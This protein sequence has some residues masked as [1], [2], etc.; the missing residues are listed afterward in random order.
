LSSNQYKEYARKVIRDWR[1]ANDPHFQH[2]VPKYSL[3]R[4]LAQIIALRPVYRVIM[5]Y[6]DELSKKSKHLYYEEM[7][8]IA[9]KLLSVDHF[10]L[11]PQNYMSGHLGLTEEAIGDLKLVINKIS[12]NFQDQ[13]DKIFYGIARLSGDPKTIEV[14]NRIT[15]KIGLC[16]QAIEHLHLL[17]Q[18]PSRKSPRLRGL[19]RLPNPLGS[20]LETL[21]KWLDESFTLQSKSTPGHAL[22]WSDWRA[23]YLIISTELIDSLSTDWFAGFPIPNWMV[24]GQGFHPEHAGDPMSLIIEE[25]T[26]TSNFVA[27]HIAHQLTYE[28]KMEVKERRRRLLQK[29]IESAFNGDLDW[30]ITEDKFKRIFNF[31]LEFNS[32]ASEVYIQDL[33]SKLGLSTSDKIT[34][35]DVWAGRTYFNVKPIYGLPDRDVGP[36]TFDDKLDIINDKIMNGYDG[37]VDRVEMAME[38]THMS[39]EEAL[40][41]SYKNMLEGTK[42]YDKF[43]RA[44][45]MVRILMI[46]ANNRLINAEK[47]GKIIDRYSWTKIKVLMNLDSE[48]PGDLGISEFQE[49]LNL[50][51]YL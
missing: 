29:A 11:S 28:C 21:L 48:Y 31:P 41:M 20:N 1:Y 36:Y 32:K 3:D 8:N 26:F 34:F 39:F 24:N 9:K 18:L 46:L 49:Y 17:E 51:F 13:Y 15:W 50:H 45:R 10:I 14:L 43:H 42:Y 4:K 44:D 16:R 2:G 25:V 6:K 19:T 23:R 27:Q 40:R 33:K 30:K 7:F 47:F 5:A 35:F 12:K 38:M 37:L 22:G